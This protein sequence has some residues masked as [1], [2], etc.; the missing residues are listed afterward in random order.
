MKTRHLLGIQAA[1]GKPQT[2]SDMGEV[3]HVGTGHPSQALLVF[4]NVYD[5]LCLE[6]KDFLFSYTL[7]VKCI[8]VVFRG[9]SLLPFCREFAPY[10]IAQ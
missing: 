8:D 7:L 6:D 9:R 10:P 4:I 2:A 5:N 3:W 1:D